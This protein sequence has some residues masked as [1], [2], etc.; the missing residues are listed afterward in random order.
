MAENNEVQVISLNKGKDNN[1]FYKGGHGMLHVCDKQEEATK[2][3]K[4]N[5]TKKIVEDSTIPIGYGWPTYK[6]EA[7]IV[8]L[9][10]MEATRDNRTFD[11]SE[12]PTLKEIA[13]LLK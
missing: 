12:M 10:T 7:V 2:Q 5:G 13:L 9:E 3:V 6:G 11:L 8:D 4:E 1:Y